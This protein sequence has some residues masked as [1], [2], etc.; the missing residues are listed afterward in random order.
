MLDSI[1]DKQRPE[2]V[3][4]KDAENTALLQIDNAKHNND[5]LL[6][7]NI[8]GGY[9]NGYL[10]DLNQEKLNW[11]GTIEFHV[12]ILDGGRT[13]AQEDEATAQYREAQAHTE[14]TKL[15]V[16]NDV[17]QALADLQSSRAR[18]K[19]TGVQIEQAQ[20]AYDIAQV[21]YKNGAA[22]NLDVL[23]AQSALEQAKLQQ[24][25]LMFSLELSQYNLN[26]A[27]GTPMW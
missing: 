3:M 24:A 25:Q 9:K 1:A 15:G 7:A 18:L 5:P 19:L 20:Q 23:T 13:H 17:E 6:S 26:K 14:D 2:I 16:E 10:P 12:P 27:I 4:A 21:R 22:T 8:T 11:I